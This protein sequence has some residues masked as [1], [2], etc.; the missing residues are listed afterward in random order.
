MN[1]VGVE[2]PSEEA[3]FEMGILVALS[4]VL[5]SLII[6]FM[7]ISWGVMPVAL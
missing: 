7:I 6:M 4:W 5:A 3:I 2:N 1:V